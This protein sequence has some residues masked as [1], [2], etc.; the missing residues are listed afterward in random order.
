MLQSL[1]GL[2]IDRRSLEAFAA[3]YLPP[4]LPDNSQNGVSSSTEP[5]INTGYGTRR[6]TDL[7]VSLWQGDLTLVRQ[8]EV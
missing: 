8:A 2:D 4:D 3:F 7:A 1:A 5:L 6:W